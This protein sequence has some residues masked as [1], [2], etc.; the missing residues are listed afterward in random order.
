[1]TAKR[2]LLLALLAGVSTCA[3]PQV[4]PWQ[5]EGA[6]QRTIAQDDADCRA[7]AQHE[8]VRRYP[9]GITPAVIGTGGVT[10]SQQRDD[11]NRSGTEQATFTRCMLGRGYRR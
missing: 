8:A 3:S 7:I 6:D 4:G 1:M 5:K 2:L 10:M 9:Y 11:V